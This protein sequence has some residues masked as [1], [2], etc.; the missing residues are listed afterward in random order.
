MFTRG[1]I[2]FPDYKTEAGYL[3]PCG[4]IGGDVMVL[5]TPLP[6]SP[7]SSQMYTFN[8]SPSR[9]RVGIAASSQYVVFAGGELINGTLFDKVDVYLVDAIQQ[10]FTSPPIYSLQLTSARRNIK[11]IVL[12]D[13]YF[14]FIGGDTVAG[15]NST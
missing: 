9:S 4:S 8:L 7:C 1:C 10:N 14:F 6:S 2:S 3:T 11:A 13:R 12:Q 5:G 15:P